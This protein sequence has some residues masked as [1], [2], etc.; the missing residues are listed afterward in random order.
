MN[1]LSYQYARN[2][3]IRDAEKHANN[4]RAS[5]RMLFAPPT[6]PADPDGPLTPG[7]F[8]ELN[9]LHALAFSNEMQ[10]LAYRAKLIAYNAEQSREY[11]SEST[12]FE[13]I[14][15]RWG[16][17]AK[18]KAACSGDRPRNCIRSQ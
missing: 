15:Q 16:K 7:Q 10:R 3:L 4:W 14:K 2:K 13:T 8:I 9:K 17:K 6:D 5:A 18:G 12:L 11:R 1:D